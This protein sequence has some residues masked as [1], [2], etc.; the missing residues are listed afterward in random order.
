[1]T[2][3]IP[4]NDSS[5]LS[6]LVFWAHKT[7]VKILDTSAFRKVTHDQIG[8]YEWAGP[9][10]SCAGKDRFIISNGKYWCRRGCGCQG[11]L[12]FGYMS[13]QELIDYT[14][15]YADNMVKAKEREHK[16]EENRKA[17]IL[18]LNKDKIHWEFHLNLINN[19]EL[20]ENFYRVGIEYD[21]IVEFTL[22]YNPHFGY[23][24]ENEQIVYSPAWTFPIWNWEHT[25][26]INI[27]HRIINAQGGMRYRP[28]Y[29]GLGNYFFHAPRSNR[30]VFI[31]EGE[32][33]A[34]VL[35]W[36]GFSAIGLFGIHDRKPEWYPLWKS[37]YQKLAVLFDN[38]NEAVISAGKIFAQELGAKW[39]DLGGKPDD[40][41]LSTDS[42]T[43]TFLALA[44]EEAL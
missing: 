2:S 14:E 6:R 30:Q 42:F 13:P 11:T 26:I 3:R 7:K 5:E 22:G 25:E 44:N 28:I 12:S 41:L 29:S 27:R 23:T 1:M 32:K 37:K 39:L 18:K 36:Y 10:P 20:L 31:V 24:N 33:K 21:A 38:D 19:P 34:I 4:I 9:C 17:K 16:L 40:L 43:K 35:W 8:G 15:I